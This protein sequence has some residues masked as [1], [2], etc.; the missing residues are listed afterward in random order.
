MSPI[1]KKQ[2]RGRGGLDWGRKRAPE[3]EQH[4][5]LHVSS[6]PLAPGP[7][8]QTTHLIFP[9]PPQNTKHYELLNYSEHGTTVDNVL[10]SCDFSEKTPPTPPSSIVAKVQNVISKLEPVATKLAILGHIVLRPLSGW[11]WLAANDLLSPSRSHWP[12]SPCPW[13]QGKPQRSQCYGYIHLLKDFQL[14][15]A[16]PGVPQP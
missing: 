8:Q 3:V 5:L 15:G 4:S 11:L 12:G 9:P 1:L 16:F 14:P 13:A 10:Y 7:T 2:G 6:L